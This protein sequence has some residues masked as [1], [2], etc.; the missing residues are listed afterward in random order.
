[1]RIRHLLWAS[2]AKVWR[3]LDTT[4]VIKRI[5]ARTPPFN[6]L[7]SLSRSAWWRNVG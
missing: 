4:L 3:R 2:K 1:M 7:F 5:G 6:G